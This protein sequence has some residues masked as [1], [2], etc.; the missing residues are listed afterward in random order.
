MGGSAWS[1]SRDISDGFVTVTERTFKQM[2]PGD[3]SKLG[4]EIERYMRELRGAA[5]ADEETTELQKR[6]R[7][8][9]RLNSALTVMRA[10]RL[11]A[12]R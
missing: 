8:I 9:Q 4:H 3:L 7:R 6:Q 11:K 2:S 5:V 10:F 12:R 1:M